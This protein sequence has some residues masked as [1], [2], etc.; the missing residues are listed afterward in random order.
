MLNRLRDDINANYGFKEGT[1]RVNCGPCIRFAIAFRERWN[2][3]FNAKAKFACLVA[4][5]LCGHVALKLPDG[6]LFRRR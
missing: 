1:P 2:S 3:R 6:Q 5:P 4:T